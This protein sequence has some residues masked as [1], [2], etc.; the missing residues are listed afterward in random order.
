MEFNFSQYE[1]T[2]KYFFFFDVYIKNNND[3]KEEIFEKLN[4]TGSTYRRA[5]NSE[6]TAGKSVITTLCD[7]YN[8]ILPDKKYIKDLEKLITKIYNKMYYKS[9]DSYDK[10]LNTIKSF[11][12]ENT[13]FKPVLQ[14][15]NMFM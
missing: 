6:S 9:F 3:K 8:L 4:I 10:D 15:I 13:I 2:Q 12:E 7:Y 14:L 5:R 1:Q 11:L